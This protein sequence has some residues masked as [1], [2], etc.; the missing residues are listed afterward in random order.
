[1]SDDKRKKRTLFDITI[2]LNSSSLFVYFS[3]WYLLLCCES[4]KDYYPPEYYMHGKCRTAIEVNLSSSSMLLWAATL[5]YID[6]KELNAL[7][8]DHFLY[9]SF[10]YYSSPQLYDFSTIER[11][12]HWKLKKSCLSNLFPLMSQKWTQQKKPSKQC[13]DYLF[14]NV[15]QRLIDLIKTSA[16]RNM[17]FIWLSQDLYNARTVSFVTQPIIIIASWTEVRIRDSLEMM[18]HTQLENDMFLCS[19]F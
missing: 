14:L 5:F 18:S 10:L 19:C 9:L 6:T 11:I 1:M 7:G 3:F 13:T 2:P 12:N 17:V 8:D 16:Y 4:F 15:Y